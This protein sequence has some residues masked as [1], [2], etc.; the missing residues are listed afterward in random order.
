MVW[1]STGWKG[2]KMEETV[3]MHVLSVVVP[4][5][6]SGTMQFFSCSHFFFFPGAVKCLFSACCVCRGRRKGLAFFLLQALRFKWLSRSFF[7][8]SKKNQSINQSLFFRLFC[9]H[10]YPCRFFFV[11]VCCPPHSVPTW[12]VFVFIVFPFFVCEAV[13]KELLCREG[14]L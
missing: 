3:T 13:L 6:C 9:P 5:P 10:V 8:S 7:T 14:V 1:V 4:F 12:P 2:K 11:V